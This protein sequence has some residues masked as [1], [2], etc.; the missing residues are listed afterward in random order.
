[1]KMRKLSKRGQEGVSLTGTV[2][3]LLLLLVV[4]VVLIFFWMRST[5]STS[6]FWGNLFGGGQVN[7][8]NVVQG[9][10]TACS[11]ALT[12]DYCQKSRDV[13]FEK[14]GKKESWT[15]VELE[16]RVPSVGMEPCDI[17]CNVQIVK[18]EELMESKCRGDANC[19]VRW[20]DTKTFDDYKQ[21]IG[22]G[23]TYSQINDITGEVTDVNDKKAA[24]HNV[25]AQV[26][27]NA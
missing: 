3:A 27:R 2:A 26:I 24:G 8:E 17:Q 15:C 6:D 21:N 12:Y 4:V 13:I 25:C 14:K 20:L 16:K 19:E 10:K 1:M 18:C 5:G 23:K 9:C 7:V 11:G 22:P